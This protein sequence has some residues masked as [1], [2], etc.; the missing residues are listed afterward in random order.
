MLNIILVKYNYRVY[1]YYIVFN[2]GNLFSVSYYY[3]RRYY[4]IADYIILLFVTEIIIRNRHEGNLM[5]SLFT[6]DLL[7][8]RV[9]QLSTHAPAASSVAPLPR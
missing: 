7:I 8:L 3:K 9:T 5:M 2:R 6:A 4:I 1:K